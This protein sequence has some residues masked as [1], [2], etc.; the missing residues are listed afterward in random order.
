MQALPFALHNGTVLAT[1]RD[2][3]KLRTFLPFGVVSVLFVLS[4]LCSS[5]VKGD[6]IYLDGVGARSMSMGG[7]DVAYAS[8]SLGAMGAN[9]AGL[10][11]LRAPSANLGLAGGFAQGEFT[12]APTSNGTLESNPEAAPEGAFAIPVGK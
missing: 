2:M 12:K 11:F 3:N 10:G 6:G 1:L 7:A 8:D 5:T 9:P 4:V